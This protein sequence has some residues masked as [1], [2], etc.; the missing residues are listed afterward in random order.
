MVLGLAHLHPLPVVQMW[1]IFSNLVPL[2]AP[3]PH[4]LSFILP[5]PPFLSP[6]LLS[7]NYLFTYLLTGS[8]YIIQD[9]LKFA[10]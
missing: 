4:F 2:S 7:L 9:G 1:Q 10:T 6:F 3:P 5:L 8:H